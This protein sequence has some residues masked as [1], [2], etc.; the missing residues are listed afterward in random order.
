MKVINTIQEIEKKIQEIK[1]QMLALG[2]MHPG[3]ISKQYHVCGQPGCRCKAATNPQRH[4]PYCKL[5]YVHQGKQVCR[6]V[7]PLWLE[8]LASQLEVYKTFKSLSDQ[9]IAL[10]I[11]RARL[12]FFDA[13]NKKLLPDTPPTRKK[14]PRSR[15]PKPQS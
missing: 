15:K 2:P 5:R 12:A 3:S 7:R 14:A 8:D 9:W 11:E 13:P 10:S 4:G 1:N 6:F